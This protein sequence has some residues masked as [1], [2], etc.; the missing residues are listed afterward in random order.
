MIWVYFF[1]VKFRTNVRICSENFGHLKIFSARITNE[2][3]YKFTIS[4]VTNYCISQKHLLKSILAQYFTTSLKISKA[5]TCFRFLLKSRGSPNHEACARS[6]SSHNY[7]ERQGITCRAARII[8]MHFTSNLLYFSKPE[9]TK[10]EA[11][12]FTRIYFS[13]TKFLVF[14]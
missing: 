12:T 6:R 3:F 1:A 10:A 13:S 8:I 9:P 5:A 11:L 14:I 2:R 4:N 7:S